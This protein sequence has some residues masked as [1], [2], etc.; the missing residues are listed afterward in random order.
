MSD[1]APKGANEEKLSLIV[2][3]VGH[4]LLYQWQIKFAGYHLQKVYWPEYR[5][6]SLGQDTN[7]GH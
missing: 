6:E 4:R 7:G 3:W 1:D 2:V 5:G